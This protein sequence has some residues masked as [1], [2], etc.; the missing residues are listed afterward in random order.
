MVAR[1]PG[2][3]LSLLPQAGCMERMIPPYKIKMVEPIKLI[4]REERE[5]AIVEAGFNPF[6]LNSKDVFIDLL[7]DSGTGAMSD[8]QWAGI[9]LGDESYAGSRNF[10]NLRNTVK[11]I[12]GFEFVIPCHQ[13]RGAEQVLNR[14]LLKEGQTVPGNIHFDTTKA[15]IEVLGGRAVDCTIDAIHDPAAEL[16]FKGDLDLDKLR[17]VIEPDPLNVAYVLITIT[18]NSGGGQPVSLQNIRDVSAICHEHKVLLYIDAARYAE[19]A[20]FIKTREPEQKNKSIRD[21]VRNIFSCVDGVLMSAKKDAIVNM[22]GFLALRDEE[23]YQKLCPICVLFE[24]FPTYGG[25]NGRDIEAMA[26]GLY[27]A[28]EEPYLAYRIGQIE[29]LGRRLEATGVPIVKPVGGHAIYID[30]KTFFPHITQDMFPAH[31][32]CVELYL[33]GGVRSVEIGTLLAGRDPDTGENIHP[34]LEL[35]RLTI[36]RRVYTQEHM[37][38]IADTVAGVWGRRH[39]VQGLDFEYEAP[40]LRHFQSRFKRSA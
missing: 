4:P 8:N 38:Y 36:P 27:E 16:P 39:D 5:R 14:V 13:G 18:N 23:L 1:L 22:G 24:G 35:T 21:I 34:A 20:W 10:H 29:Y 2:P 6:L 37:D 31:T 33:E 15:H 25:M 19:N 40:I 12:M 30:A 3:L 17:A 26:R 11:D 7:T 32:L 9:M 28:I